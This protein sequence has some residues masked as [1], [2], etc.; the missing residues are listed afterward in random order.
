MNQDDV[1]ELL[2]LYEQGHSLEDIGDHFHRS[3]TRVRQ[4]LQASGRW[5]PR[6]RGRPRKADVDTVA[7][8]WRAGITPNEIAENLDCSP[9]A[10]YRALHQAGIRTYVSRKADQ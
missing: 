4:V 9:P 8:L 1:P 6:T 10:V 5:E 2:A 7:A 3:A